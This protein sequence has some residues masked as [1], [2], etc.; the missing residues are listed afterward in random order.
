MVSRLVIPE[1]TNRY[2]L[3]EKVLIQSRTAFYWNIT[4]IC[5]DPKPPVEALSRDSFLFADN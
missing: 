3:A 2:Y 4:K 1:R 5:A